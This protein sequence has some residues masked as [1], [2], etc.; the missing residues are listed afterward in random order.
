MGSGGSSD[1]GGGGVWTSEGKGKK[2]LRN[3][4]FGWSCW[5][6]DGDTHSDEDPGQW[7]WEEGMA[8]NRTHLVHI[9]ALLLG[10]PSFPSPSSVLK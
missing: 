9:Q 5:E 8:P 3:T 1:E 4:R 2:G 6:T 10:L 7:G